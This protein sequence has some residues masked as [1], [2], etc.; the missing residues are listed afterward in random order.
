LEGNNTG[1]KRSI[2]RQN[3]QLAGMDDD[4]LTLSQVEMA[5]DEAE[6]TVAHLESDI[7]DFRRARTALKDIIRGLKDRSLEIED[8]DY[9]SSDADE[10]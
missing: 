6:E 3:N 1:L 4:L 5:R 10:E 8:V 9:P 2:E 7:D